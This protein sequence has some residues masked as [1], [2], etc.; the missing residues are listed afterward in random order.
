[1]GSRFEC[2]TALVVVMFSSQ[3][4]CHGLCSSPCNSMCGI[5]SYYQFITRS[6]ALCLHVSF[7]DLF[8]EL[9]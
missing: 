8:P 3:T 5:L 4:V 2:H 9:V 6:L 7:L 1:M